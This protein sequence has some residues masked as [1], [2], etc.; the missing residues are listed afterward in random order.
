[1]STTP[2]RYSADDLSFCGQLACPDVQGK[3]PGILIFPEAPGVGPHVIRRAAA[4]A[5]MNYV[6]LAADVHGEG[7]LF[8]DPTTMRA[9]IDQLKSQPERL[10]QRLQASL[11]ALAQVPQVDPQRMLVIG[12][13]FG[14]WCALELART[15]APLLGVGVFHGALIPTQANT[16]NR[17][18]GKV[19]VCSGASD[20]LVPTEQITAFTQE[21][22]AAGVDWQVHLYGGT[23]H[24]FTS[25]EAGSNPRPGFGYSAAS[26]HRSWAALG[27]FLNETF[28]MGKD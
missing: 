26:D 16:A 7:V 8:D 14:G 11:Q 6:A 10:I 1:M 17:I 18:Q 23:G 20:P 24:G 4:L 5:R 22:S 27:V 9:N 19:L 13:C 25:P 2:L 12:Y 15:G 21:M 3:V 28:D